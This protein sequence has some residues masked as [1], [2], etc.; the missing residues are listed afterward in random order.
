MYSSRFQEHLYDESALSRF[1][2]LT[3]PIYIC[4]KDRPYYATQYQ[5]IFIQYQE[6]FYFVSGKTSPDFDDIHITIPGGPPSLIP[7]TKANIRDRYVI[8]QESQLYHK[9]KKYE[10]LRKQ[11]WFG[12]V[13]PNVQTDAKLDYMIIR[14]LLEMDQTS[15]NIYKKLCDL[16]RDFKQTAFILLTRKFPLNGYI[17]TG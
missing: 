5:D 1:E 17:I 12:A 14:I 8:R 9:S 6:G 11:N 13:Q 7:Y 10:L 4:N 3:K 16:D 2:V 15:L